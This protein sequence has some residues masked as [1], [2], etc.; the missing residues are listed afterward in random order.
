MIDRKEVVKE[1]DEF[2][3][4][5]PMS[6]WDISRGS[7]ASAQMIRRLREGVPSKHIKPLML[8]LK[9]MREYDK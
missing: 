3:L 6:L 2:L 7:G 5:H 1:L 9:F 8:L 4:K